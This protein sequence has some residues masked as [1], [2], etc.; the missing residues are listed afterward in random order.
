[1]ADWLSF[2]NQ[3]T[4]A[5]KSK[6]KGKV[7]GSIYIPYG[8]GLVHTGDTVYCVGIEGGELLLITR[9]EVAKT[10]KHPNPRW[11][12]VTAAPS[13]VAADYGRK[14]PKHAIKLLR[15]LHTDGQVHK[16]EF[17]GASIK[18]AHFQGLSSVRKLTKGAPD[19]DALLAAKK[20]A[21]TAPPAKKPAPK[22]TLAKKP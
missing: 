4:R 20:P 11:I 17:N 19:L 18:H 22:T 21:S 10:G 12:N 8:N 13:N 6:L 1:M 14:V 7:V 9:I 16:F 3:D 2:W 5:K 15:F